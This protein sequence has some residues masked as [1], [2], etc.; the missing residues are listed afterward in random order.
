[1]LKGEKGYS[2]FF[3]RFPDRKTRILFSVLAIIFSIMLVLSGSFEK[4]DS[5]YSVFGNARNIVISVLKMLGWFVFLYE[6]SRLAVTLYPGTALREKSNRMA[7]GI[8]GQKKVVLTL[9]LIIFI[10]WLPYYI[11]S[12]PGNMTPDSQDQL[13]QIF[14]DKEN[15]WTYNSVIHENPEDNT[16]NNHHPVFYTCFL[17]A[18]VQLGRQVGDVNVGIALFS[19]VQMLLTIGGI[20]YFLMFLKK[21]KIPVLYLYLALAFF[22]LYPIFPMYA[23]TVSKDMLFAVALLWGSVELCILLDGPEQGWNR[24]L[25]TGLYILSLTF[26]CLLRSNGAYILIAL[27]PFAVAAAKRMRGRMLLCTLT[28]LILYFV[29]FIRIILPAF[30]IRANANPREMLSV[31]LQQVARYAAAYGEDGFEEGELTKLNQ[32]MHFMEDTSILARRYNPTSSDWVKGCFDKNPAGEDMKNFL[33]VWLKLVA[34]HPGTCMAATLNNIYLLTNAT[35][36]AEGAKEFLVY[37]NQTETYLEE[38]DWYG[39]KENRLFSSLRERFDGILLK[40][41]KIPVLGAPFTIGWYDFL[42]LFCLVFCISKKKYKE[43]VCILPML[44]CIGTT[45]L[46][47]IIY[48][49]YAVQWIFMVPMAGAMCLSRTHIYA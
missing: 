46:G 1:M 38:K 14:Q 41:S 20:V 42:I 32:V 45:V 30:E 11:I 28:P 39:V 25:H 40:W 7:E 22:S 18:F 21:K 15:S 23:I 4:S 9:F 12:I 34:R 24:R 27:L 13:A 37:V 31:P 43:A 48:M 10:C 33:K 47:P 19:F 44:F 3:R 49:R 17:G 36:A 6:G 2:K 16:I 5:L 8:W 26:V 29:I 35:G